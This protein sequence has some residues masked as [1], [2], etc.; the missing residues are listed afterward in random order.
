LFI[1]EFGIGADRGWQQYPF[2]GVVWVLNG[3]GPLY[4]VVVLP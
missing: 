2:G 4:F 3:L 1:K